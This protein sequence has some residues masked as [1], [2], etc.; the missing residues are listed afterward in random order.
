MVS[1]LASST[2]DD[3][4]VYGMSKMSAGYGGSVLAPRYSRYVEISA[5]KSRH[6]E[7]RNSHIASFVL[8]RPVEV[9]CPPPPAGAC[10]PSPCSIAACAT[11]SPYSAEGS[12]AQP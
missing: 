5:P 11:W 1:E 12:S 9:S 2:N 10:P 6:S 8:G 4:D 7:D 3:T